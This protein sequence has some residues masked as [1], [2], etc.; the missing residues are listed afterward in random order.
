MVDGSPRKAS[1]AT[2]VQT[3]ASRFTIIGLN[4]ATGILT[5]RLLAP[6]G[7]GELAAMSIWPALVA[8]LTTLGLPTALIYHGRRDPARLGELTVSALTLAA[9]GG[10]IGTAIAWAVIPIWLQQHPPAIIMAARFCLFATVINSMTLVGRAAWEARGDFRSSNL[11]QVAAPAMTIVGLVGL[12]ATGH[13]TSVTA[14]ITYVGVSLPVLVWMLAGLRPDHVLAGRETTAAWRELAHYGARSYGVD[15]FGVLSVYL[16]QALVVGMLTPVAM[17][18]YAVA[19]SLARIV[20]AVHVGTA[21]LMLP[22]VVGYSTD[23][24]TATI[25]RS[26]RLAAVFTAAIGL[27]IVV[28]GPLLVERL[29]GRAYASAG[30]LL[31]IL[32]LAMIVGGTTYVLMQG[33]LAA[34]RPGIVTLTQ[35][36]GL[37]LGTPFFFILIPSSGSQGAAIALLASATIRLALVMACYPLALRAPLPRIWLNRK[38]VPELVG[39]VSSVLKLGPAA[40]LRTGAAE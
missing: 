4:A 33:L 39:R 12:A 1:T 10:L 25:A 2:V 13:L 7:R 36:V 18:I 11:T 23:A 5:A 17:G 35:F 15:L 40:W 31:P 16:D 19:T 24:L 6:E 34:G 22:T 8:G 14:A 37:A 38:D 20:S 26:A 27:V 30:P 21:T 3:I 29:Y 9:I 32:V 28:A